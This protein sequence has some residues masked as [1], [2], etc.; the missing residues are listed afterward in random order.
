MVRILVLSL[1]AVG[2]FADLASAQNLLPPI[3]APLSAP[4][5]VHRGPTGQPCLTF[6]SFSR[7]QTLNKKIYEHWVRAKN[8]CG[9]F[10]K[11]QVCYYHTDDCITMNVAPW[12]DKE[13]VLGIYPSLQ[14]F[15][16]ET[17]EEF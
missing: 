17:K 15:R 7:A 5:L 1:V 9:K 3:G 12:E 14:E 8:S 16:F 11:V 13:A 4:V 10:I 6:Q 2:C